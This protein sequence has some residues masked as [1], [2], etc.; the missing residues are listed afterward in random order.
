MVSRKPYGRYPHETNY[1]YPLRDQLDGRR[2]AEP[3]VSAQELWTNGCPPRL[4]E[5]HHSFF[6]RVPRPASWTAVPGASLVRPAR[7]ASC[8]GYL[9]VTPAAGS[10]VWS[11]S[12]AVF[13][14]SESGCHRC[15]DRVSA[16][17]V[18]SR[19]ENFSEWSVPARLGSHGSPAA[20]KLPRGTP[21][22]FRCPCTSTRRKPDV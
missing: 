4:L 2:K 6:Q 14:T 20:T 8:R 22:V 11:I 13:Q 7:S 1:G 18:R 19:H 17:L 5:R 10:A 16:G 15:V 9:L 21:V 3:L 12:D